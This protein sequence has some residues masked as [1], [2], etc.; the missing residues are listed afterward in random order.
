MVSLTVEGVGLSPIA[1][2]S[3]FRFLCSPSVLKSLSSL[4]FV[5]FS[6]SGEIVKE[7]PNGGHFSFTL[8]LLALQVVCDQVVMI[9]NFP[10][11]LLASSL[12]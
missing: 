5:L 12:A 6:L 1:L 8:N 4:H 3:V 9:P 7:S 10:H 11:F 2:T